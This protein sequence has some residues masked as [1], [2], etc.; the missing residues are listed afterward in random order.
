MPDG[1]VLSP[2][3]SWVLRERWDVLEPQTLEEARSVAFTAV[4]AGFSLNLEPIFA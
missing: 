1:A 2:D 3:A 4:L